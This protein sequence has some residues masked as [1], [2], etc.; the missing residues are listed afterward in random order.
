MFNQRESD[1]NTYSYMVADIWADKNEMILTV[2]CALTNASD[3]DIDLVAAAKDVRIDDK[4]CMVAFGAGVNPA[5]FAKHKESWDTFRKI[6]E[7]RPEKTSP[8]KSVE[9]IFLFTVDQ[10]RSSWKLTY[11]GTV[12]SEINLRQ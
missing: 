7:K 11:K 10:T 3:S 1:M 12:V 8:G 9:L 6:R 4:P 2:N 5:P